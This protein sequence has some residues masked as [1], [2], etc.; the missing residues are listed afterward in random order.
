MNIIDV[1]IPL[2]FGLL[3]IFSPQLFVKQTSENFQ[4]K[5]VTM[6]KI[7]IFFIAVSV[8]YLII[9]LATSL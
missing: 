8:V 5:K 6:R 4:K 3:L 2:V 9:K 7:G 1:L